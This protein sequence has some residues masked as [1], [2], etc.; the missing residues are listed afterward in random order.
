M[1]L[2]RSVTTISR[3]ISLGTAN[4]LGVQ[5]DP[6]RARFSELALTCAQKVFDVDDLKFGPISWM[7]EREKDTLTYS[8]HC[9][10][11]SMGTV[12]IA[13]FSETS[14]SSK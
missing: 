3:A 8:W 2:V 13:E 11:L 5:S 7:V 10:T 1:S 12:P 6:N 9:L 14:K 4:F